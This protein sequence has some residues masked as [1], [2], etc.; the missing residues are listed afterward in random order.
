MESDADPVLYACAPCKKNKRRC[1]KRV[2]SCGS[3]L[4]TGRVC[5]YSSPPQVTP[6]SEISALQR[7]VQELEEHVRQF[8]V[9]MPSVSSTSGPVD[10]N[11]SIQA[12]YLD[13]EVWSS[14]KFPDRP[15][16]ILAPDD[17]CAA[18]G[19]Q[20]DI[21]SI[22]TG[23]FQSI[24]VWLPFVSKIRVSRLTQVPQSCPKTDI[25]LLLLCMRLIQEVPDR[26]GPH[27]LDLYN[28]A[29]EFSKRLELEGL[30]TLSTV[31]AGVLLLL[32]EIGHGIF[33]AAFMTISYCARQGVALGLH[34]K[35]APQLYGKPRFWGDW[36]ERQRVWWTIMILDR[37]VAIGGGYRPLCTD[38]PGRDTFLPVD[39][40]AW[41]SGEM[42]PPERVS[43]SSKTITKEISSFARLAQASNLLG[44]V[45][46]HCGDSSLE[47]NFMLDGFET[48]C[49]ANYSLLELLQNQGPLTGLDAVIARTICY[50]A[51]FKLSDSYSCELFYEETQYDAQTAPRVRQCLE[52]SLHIMNDICGQVTTLIQEVRGLLTP[53][54]LKTASPLMLECV[55]T[56]AQ[57]ILWISQETNNQQ[58]ASAKMVS[59]D[60]LRFLDGR[61]KV[62]DLL[63]I[64]V[65]LELTKRSEV[66]QDE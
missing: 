40:D 45:I 19:D 60:M 41:N 2:P 58:L 31:Q 55:Y 51:L 6:E 35:F 26:Y 39:D 17:I 37:Y 33:P 12:F 36:E 29:K 27:S 21:D 54:T 59:E 46:R 30:L 48:L 56:C 62:A 61:W 18:L 10:S 20:A 47:I 24:H 22:K 52:R 5:D 34:N 65:Y 50:S 8:P 3:C 66:G 57:S 9:Q 32:Y 14:L 42:V 49:Q 25:A 64:G 63:R 53:E 44:R 15:A 11:L 1:D 23:Y 13:S 38:D 4:K 7:R 16:Q 28:L 43:L